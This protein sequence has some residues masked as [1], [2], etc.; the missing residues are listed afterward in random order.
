MDPD[1]PRLPPEL[2]RLIFELAVQLHRPLAATLARVASR[3]KE[4]VE[5]ELYRVAIFRGNVGN[6][7]ALRHEFPYKTGD[8]LQTR[9]HRYSDA[10]AI[11][12]WDLPED[13]EEDA[14]CQHA[15]QLEEVALWQPEDD[16]STP[17]NYRVATF[18][19]HLPLRSLSVTSLDALRPVLSSS[20]Q[21]PLFTT[22]THL[23]VLTVDCDNTVLLNLSPC[24]NLT[25]LAFHIDRRR[26]AEDDII[27]L[28]EVH[29]RL[30]VLVLAES[31]DFEFASR[32]VDPN[33]ATRV[34]SGLPSHILQRIVYVSVHH[35]MGLDDW[36]DDIET[37]DGI[38]GN[39][40]AIMQER[41][42]RETAAVA[43]RAG[44]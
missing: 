32:R 27:R 31:I 25:H 40:D 20:G 13:E 3:V 2:E 33:A 36:F 9:P 22:L 34:Y 24:H 7:S 44:A 4:W 23:T 16:P 39:A 5:A 1:S 17:K 35:Y 26:W 18:I 30:S 11:L 43:S 10:R 38:F 42:T 15:T 8:A 6:D 28:F 37:A 12:I 19:S 29:H 21:L 14:F 41:Q